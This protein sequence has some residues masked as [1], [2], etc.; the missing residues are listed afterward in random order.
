MYLFC[1]CSIQA[2]IGFVRDV[3]K[4]RA[5]KRPSRFSSAGIH[6]VLYVK[7]ICGLPFV[8][9][10]S[11]FLLL[12]LAVLHSMQTVFALALCIQS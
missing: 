12:W 7:V 3:F 4:G 2:H 9:S 8:V 1:T 6:W 11:V 10:S 5:L